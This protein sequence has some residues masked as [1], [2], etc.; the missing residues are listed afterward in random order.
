MVLEGYDGCPGDLS[1]K[2]FLVDVPHQEYLM[3]KVV[4]VQ[5]GTSWIY[6]LIVQSN[7]GL[8]QEEWF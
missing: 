4:R 2:I 1:L 6:K 3:S 5:S 7:N 8:R